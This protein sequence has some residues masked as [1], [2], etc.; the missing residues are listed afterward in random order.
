MLSGQ[1]GFEFIMMEMRLFIF[2][3]PIASLIVSVA[4][5]PPESPEL[6]YALANSNF[7]NYSGPPPKVDNKINL[8]ILRGNG[9]KIKP[10]LDKD[11]E[12][13]KELSIASVSIDDFLAQ[14]GLDSDV[15]DGLSGK[16]GDELIAASLPNSANATVPSLP[17][18][19]DKPLTHQ[20]II[21]R[22][23]LPSDEDDISSNMMVADFDKVNK[24]TL[25]IVGEGETTYSLARRFCSTPQDIRLRNDLDD[26]FAIKKG[27]ILTIPKT[28][29]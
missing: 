20:R 28:T 7:I 9:L 25:H 15:D 4:P 8:D 3:I 26:S 16:N 1:N 29:C 5:P 24:A 12:A 17:L 6:G 13:S 27:Q 2:A 11:S 14:R 10:R 21:E 22:Q 19:E 23:D 18:Q